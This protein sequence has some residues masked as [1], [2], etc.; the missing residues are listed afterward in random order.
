MVEK[1]DMMT[2]FT[3]LCELPRGSCTKRKVSKPFRVGVVLS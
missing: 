1:V 2:A 3:A